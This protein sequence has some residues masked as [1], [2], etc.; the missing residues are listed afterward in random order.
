MNRA[1]KVVLAVGL[2]IMLVMALVP[3]WRVQW[4]VMETTATGDETAG[5]HFLFTNL[6]THAATE[7]MKALKYWEPSFTGMQIDA[8]RLA[9]QVFAVAIVTALGVIC[10]G[11]C[12]PRRQKSKISS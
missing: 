12:L 6:D 8:R 1:Q 10:S 11:I 3:P 4:A 2:A 7:A 5:Y 9:V